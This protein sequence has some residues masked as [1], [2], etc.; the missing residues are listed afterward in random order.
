MIQAEYGLFFRAGLSYEIVF[1]ALFLNAMQNTEVTIL[2]ERCLVHPF[3]EQAIFKANPAMNLCM[4]LNM[5][6][7]AGKLTDDIVDGEPFRFLKK[8]AFGTLENRSEK[9]FKQYSA[10]VDR[11]YES[12]RT[13]E[14][15][16]TG[17]I[18]AIAALFGGLLSRLLQ[19]MCRESQLSP[20]NPLIH[21]SELLGRWIYCIDAVDD[22]RTDFRKKRYNPLIYQYK[23]T[24]FTSYP[25]EE[26][27]A[28]IISQEA[29]RL[30]LLS[31]HMMAE[32]RL[33]RRQLGLYSVEID[34]IIFRSIPYTSARI[35][36]QNME[37]EKK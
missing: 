31:E 21:F 25:L 10:L 5:A 35:V 20:P 37:K 33:F 3:R 24:F 28:S 12:I 1:F 18:D 19:E 23:D 6:L 15:Q 7:I 4:H 9:V 22:L 2:H 26:A 13:C 34:D 32:Y 17:D 27:F 29:I 16:K 8:F 14:T 30:R 11:T 36:R